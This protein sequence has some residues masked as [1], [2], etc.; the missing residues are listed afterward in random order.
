MLLAKSTAVVIVFL[1]V[2]ATDDETAETGLSPAVEISKNGGA[3][4]AVTNSVSE[5]SN[6]WYKVTLTTTETNTNG[7]LIIRATGTGADEW[8]DVHQVM[9]NLPLT[10]AQVNAEVDTA[11]SDY[12]PPTKTEMDAA[13][14]AI[15]ALTVADVVTAFSD[16]DITPVSAMSSDG[17]LTITVGATLETVISGLTIPTTWDVMHLMVKHKLTAD[18]SAAK[19]HILVTNGGDAG[20]GLQL[21]NGAAATAGNGSL[22]VNQ[23]GGTVTVY[24]ADD[25]AAELATMTGFF[26][27]KY[28]RDDGES[29]VCAEGKCSVV[30]Y[31]MVDPN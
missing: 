21:I 10:A 14:A 4:A 22:S 24:L 30:R 15:D 29:V 19:V 23:S 7:P 1:M 11:L 5:I 20:D 3:F 13:I 17:E 2:D 27:L 26:A 8:R 12:D 18:D 25:A 31:A 9:S 6:G 28:F 16:Y